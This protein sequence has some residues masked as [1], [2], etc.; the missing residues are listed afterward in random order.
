[1][2]SVIA[3]T[4]RQLRL[5]LS[6][7][8]ATWPYQAWPII[9]YIAFE[10]ID[11]NVDS[12]RHIAVAVAQR[13][14]EE[15]LGIKRSTVND[16][17]A[18]LLR[19]RVLRQWG[20]SS[21]SAP[22]WL[23]IREVR[24][25]DV[26]WRIERETVMSLVKNASNGQPYDWSQ[27]P[28]Y[29][30]LHTLATGKV[31]RPKPLGIV[32]LRRLAGPFSTDVWDG[33]ET[34][35]LATHGRP[36]AVRRSSRGSAY[37]S[38]PSE[39]NV[40]TT[41]HLEDEGAA[42]RHLKPETARVVATIE[43]IIGQKLY[44]NPSDSTRDYLSRVIRASDSLSDA[45]WVVDAFRG[46][47]LRDYK[48]RWFQVVTDVVSLLNAGP[49]RP[50]LP[51]WSSE[52]EEAPEGEVLSREEQAERIATAKADLRQTRNAKEAASG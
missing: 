6:L 12:G 45:T 25:W 47:S 5:A 21:G 29:G 34:D 14:I 20:R 31:K 17:L 18:E 40:S 15:R 46:K 26:E 42:E 16:V 28:V 52:P 49:P 9:D 1:M 38:S 19:R 23:Q 24:E 51:D 2:V 3:P 35:A 22:R 33:Q 4:S 13:T 36:S 10:T 11:Y 39:K 32:L 41:N 44:D 48:G 30:H 7:V 8:E 50:R 27:E 43:A 37:G